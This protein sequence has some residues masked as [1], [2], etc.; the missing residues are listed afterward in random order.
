MDQIIDIKLLRCKR[1]VKQPFNKL[2]CKVG[3]EEKT[4]QLEPALID[5]NNESDA[6]QYFES[7]IDKNG[8]VVRKAAKYGKL[9]FLA[10]Y[11]AEN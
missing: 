1:D 2:E 11:F 4:V 5:L 3:E 8:K 10:E 6:K 7:Q 9:L